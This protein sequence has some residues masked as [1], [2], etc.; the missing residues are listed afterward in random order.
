VLA[1]FALG[2]PPRTSPLYRR[3]LGDWDG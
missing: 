1:W 2:M 3:L